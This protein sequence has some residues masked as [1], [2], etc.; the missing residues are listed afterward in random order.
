M[1]ISDK[2]LDNVIIE[3]YVELYKNSIPSVD[4]KKLMDDAVINDNGQKVIDFNSYEIELEKMDKII[5]N[6]TKKYKI[7]GWTKKMF[8]TTIYLG[9][10]PNIKK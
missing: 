4:F 3:C 7:K 2:K 6:I 1:R 9:C 8:T 10:S 5:E